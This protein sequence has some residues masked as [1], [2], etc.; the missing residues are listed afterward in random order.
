MYANLDAPVA[1]VAHDAGAANHIL[2]WLRCGEPGDWLPCLAGPALKLW[3]Q[4]FEVVVQSDLTETISQCHTLLSGT[5]WASDLEHDARRIARQFGVKSIAVVDHW[6]NYRERF[7]RNGEEI[8]PDE[9]WVSDGH[10]KRMA[11]TL[12]PQILVV[13]QPNLYQTTLV[14]EIGPIVPDRADRLLYVLEPV[15]DW[16]RSSQAGEFAALDYFMTRLP[17]LKISLGT[18]IRL[19]P[20][21]SDP[22]GKYDQW[23]LRQRH[24]HIAVDD[25]PTLGAALAWSTVVVGCQTYAMVIAAAAGRKVFSSLPPCAPACVLPQPEIIRLSELTTETDGSP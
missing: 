24:P 14:Q 6:T 10:A 17:A 16:T 11:G 4:S 25:S 21:P 2:A 13:Q 3:Q 19:R 9:I 5:G 1:V 18:T 22:P 23:I 7:V 12:F 8:L 20:H 15:R